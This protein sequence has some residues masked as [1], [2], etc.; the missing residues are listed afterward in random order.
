[1]SARVRTPFFPFSKGF[2][3]GRTAITR[4][5]APPGPPMSA[6]A[7]RSRKPRS[8]ARAA[9]T[10]LHGDSLSS[11]APRPGQ[12][13]G[14][15][16][17]KRRAARVRGTGRLIASPMRCTRS[18]LVLPGLPGG[19]PATMTILSPMAQRLRLTR[20]ESTSCT[21]SSVWCTVGDDER[22]DAPG[23]GELAPDRR[24]GGERE[25]RDRGTVPGEAARGL[26]GHG[27]RDQRLG[28]DDRADLGGGAG[29]R[30]AGGGGHPRQVVL[31]AQRGLL[32]RGDDP[33]HGGDRLDR[34]G[35]DAGLGGQHD[36]VAPAAIAPATSETSARVGRGALIIDSSIWVATMTGLARS[37]A[38]LIACVWM[39]GTCSRGSSTPRSPRATMIPSN[40]STMSGRTATASGF[41][42][43][44]ISGTWAAHVGHD[45]AGEVRVVRRA[46]E[47]H[48]DDVHADRQGPAQV[49]LVLVGERGRADVDPGQVDALVVGDLPADDD[50][51]AHPVA[52][53]A[54]DIEL[55]V[56]VVDQD[57]VT[58]PDVVGRPS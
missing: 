27:E 22:L 56:A 51:Q 39:A 55:D 31:G 32:R 52:G 46:D 15:A 14:H 53:D 49:R 19:L 17:R 33:A 16:G 9:R 38:S 12:A 13:C 8:Q 44:A 10:K 34:V 58:R 36:R 42:I 2:L 43:L 18:A 6:Q 41:S 45:L 21:M 50:P 11:R 28:P 3:A 20:A 47:G 57:A 1:M 30:A 54:G 4:G 29:D 24:V 23:E 5:V 7:G 48:R 37:L 40:A 26:A 25:Q 35:A